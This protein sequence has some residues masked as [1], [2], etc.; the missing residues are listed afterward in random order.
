MRF[1]ALR[2]KVNCK[3]EGGSLHSFPYF[4][5]KMELAGCEKKFKTRRETGNANKILMQVKVNNN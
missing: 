1:M 3:I 2:P 5:L 4:F